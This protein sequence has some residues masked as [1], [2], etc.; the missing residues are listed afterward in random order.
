[1]NSD[2]YPQVSGLL[3]PQDRDRYQRVDIGEAWRSSG[4]GEAFTLSIT[5]GA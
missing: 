5:G 3:Q 1:M 4:T 2:F